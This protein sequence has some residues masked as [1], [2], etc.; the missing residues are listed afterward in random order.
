MP[1]KGDRIWGDRLLRFDI[2]DNGST[3]NDVK[4]SI[5]S[6]EKGI[7]SANGGRPVATWFPDDGQRTF[8]YGWS[9]VGLT[10]Y[11]GRYKVVVTS[12]ASSPSSHTA[13]AER[14]DLRVDNPPNTVAAPKI[15][16]KTVGGVTISWRKAVEP[17]VLS[18]SVY[19]ASSKSTKTPSYSAFRKVG[20]TH[21]PS[22]RDTGLESGNHWY[23]V[24]VTRRSVVTP[25]VGISSAMSAVSRHATVVSLD[26]P[27]AKKPGGS[28]AGSSH[29]QPL[30]P[31]SLPHLPGA[32]G[33]ALPDGSFV[34]KLPYGDVPEI[35]GRQVPVSTP[36]SG[37][38]DPR[39]PVLPVAVGMFLVSSALAVGRMPY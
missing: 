13:S 29:S 24:R 23:A 14:V 19:R 36:T 27:D 30:P 33:G 4:L 7:P 31:L 1:P 22:F 39:G 8:W 15:V 25:E 10:P 32:V 2:E 21:V 18:Y 6:Q 37:P 34:W 35:P 28:A 16:A 38:V 17:D 5:L 12:T 3:I 9:S 20:V 11:N 26:R